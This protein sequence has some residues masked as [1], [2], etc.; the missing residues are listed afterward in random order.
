MKRSS[1]LSGKLSDRTLVAV[2]LLAIVGTNIH[3]LGHKAAAT[4][5]TENTL[6]TAE[7]SSACT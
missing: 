5:T 4:L 3:S 1:D 2:T 7:S 6:Q